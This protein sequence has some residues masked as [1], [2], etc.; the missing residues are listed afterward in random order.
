MKDFIAHFGMYASEDDINSI[1]RRLDTDD[2]EQLSYIEFVEA[3]I[4]SNLES[5][6][7]ER[8]PP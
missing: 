5:T 2:D 4:P 1:L 3:L 8:K 7:I 6:E